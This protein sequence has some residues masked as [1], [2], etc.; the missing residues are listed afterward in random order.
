MVETKSPQGEGS[1]MLMS[2][3]E[4]FF[5]TDLNNNNLFLS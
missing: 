1:C 5:L 4:K 2:L 3:L